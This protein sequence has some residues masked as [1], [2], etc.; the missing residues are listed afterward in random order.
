MELN[1][2]CPPRQPFS[3]TCRSPRHCCQLSPERCSPPVGRRSTVDANLTAQPPCFSNLSVHIDPPRQHFRFRW[4]HCRRRIPE[5]RERGETRRRSRETSAEGLVDFNISDEE[6]GTLHTRVHFRCWRST[7]IRTG[8]S[9]RFVGNSE[10]KRH[11]LSAGLTIEHKNLGTIR[12][13]YKKLRTLFLPN[14]ACR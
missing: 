4:A 7:P 11:F 10:I 12:G 13:R 9:G 5:A 8:L 6:F 1:K 2:G 14:C 3:P